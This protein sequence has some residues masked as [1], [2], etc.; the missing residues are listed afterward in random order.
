[1]GVGNAGVAPGAGGVEARFE[2]SALLS[3]TW[4]AYPAVGACPRQISRKG[5]KPPR[6]SWRLGARSLRWT[7][8]FETKGRAHGTQATCASTQ[9]VV[10]DFVELLFSPLRL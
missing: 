5:A 8:V 3:C 2:E 7:R 10:V 9:V 1:M 6:S 4:T